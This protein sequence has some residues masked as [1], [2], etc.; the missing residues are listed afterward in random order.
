M[1]TKVL[2]HNEQAAQEFWAANEAPRASCNKHFTFSSDE[3]DDQDDGDDEY[4]SVTSH[5]CYPDDIPEFITI[6]LND[7]LVVTYRPSRGLK[8]TLKAT[9][10]ALRKVTKPS[11]TAS[12]CPPSAAKSPSK[13]M[14]FRKRERKSRKVPSTT[15][16]EENHLSQAVGNNS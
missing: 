4:F 12:T 8:T 6:D 3:Y 10:D 5:E 16:N 7:I 11:R 2:F 1:P 15:E 14:W 9:R 13:R